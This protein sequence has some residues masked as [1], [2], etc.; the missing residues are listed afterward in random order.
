[1]S[2]GLAEDATAAGATTGGIDHN[3]RDVG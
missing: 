1:V 3:A 2:W